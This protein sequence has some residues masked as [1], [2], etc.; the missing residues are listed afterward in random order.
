LL[1]VSIRCD[2][3]S[4]IVEV[5]SIEENQIEEK[6]SKIFIEKIGNKITVPKIWIEEYDE[7]EITN[8]IKEKFGENIEI[9]I[10]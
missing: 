9:E 3:C 5:L 8:A 10:V 4:D 1:S 6:N 7:E 2:N